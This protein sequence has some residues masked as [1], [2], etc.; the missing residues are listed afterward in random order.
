MSV[1]YLSIVADVESQIN[2]LIATTPA[3]A[4]STYSAAVAGTW[5]IADRTSTDWGLPQLSNAVFDA[6]YELLKE[7]CFNGRHPERSPFLAASAAITSSSAIPATNSGGSTPFLGIWDYVYETGT[8]KP[9]T[10]RPFQV[11]QWAAADAGGAFSSPRVLVYSIVGGYLFHNS[12]T[13]AVITGPAVARATSTSGD[14]RLR[15]YHRPAVVA[16]ALIKLLPKEGAWMD[17]YKLNADYYAA[18]IDQIRSIGQQMGVPYPA[19]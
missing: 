3:L 8:A 13:T 11:V 5:T 17:A 1:S 16:G 9:M 6:E 2:G 15:D 14:M 7:I 19:R 12:T 18:H 4:E 10:E